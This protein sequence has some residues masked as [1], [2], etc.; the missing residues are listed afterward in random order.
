MNKDIIE[1]NGRLF[2][3][4]SGLPLEA[5]PETAIS[6]LLNPP[7][8]P[9]QTTVKLIDQ[10]P[11]SATNHARHHS[12]NASRLLMRQAVKK[13]AASFKRQLRVQA[14]LV[15]PKLVPETILQSVVT[16]RQKRLEMAGH[17]PKS[18][19][20]IHFSPRHAV[21][22]YVDHQHQH[23]Q[24][25]PPLAVS[26]HTVLPSAPTPELQAR[27]G[28]TTTDLLNRALREAKAHEQPLMPKPS[29]RSRHSRRLF[30]KLRT[31]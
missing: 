18:K 12:Q 3:A 9:K 29:H 28:Q 31:A 1:I 2:D 15:T 17:F 21:N 16:D 30:T 19:S 20:V 5:A 14:V 11:H 4:A 23:M 8:P 25:S 7:S 6:V 22:H 27:S 10:R 13:P 24:S 26:E